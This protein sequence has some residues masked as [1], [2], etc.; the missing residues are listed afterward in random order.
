MCFSV[1]KFGMYLGFAYLRVCLVFVHMFG[2]FTVIMCAVCV[3]TLTFVNLQYAIHVPNTIFIRSNHNIK[4]GRWSYS[5]YNQARR[6]LMV[7]LYFYHKGN[8]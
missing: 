8:V 7:Q 4:I 3:M 2:L 6:C 1:D 5:L